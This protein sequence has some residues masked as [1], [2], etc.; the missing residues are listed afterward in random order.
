MGFDFELPGEF[1]QA[2]W[3]GFGPGQKY[4]DTGLAARLGWFNASIEEL[5]VPYVRPQE[6]G[7]RA[8]VSHLEIAAPDAGQSITFQSETMWFTLRPWSQEVLTAAKH[9]PDL[10]ADGISYLTLDAAVHGI[11]TASCGTGVLPA[12]RLAPGTVSF[13]VVLS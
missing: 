8:G 6:N 2:S 12:Y 11:G 5:Q 13:T 1:S 3:T 10:V 4:P 9:T 7:A